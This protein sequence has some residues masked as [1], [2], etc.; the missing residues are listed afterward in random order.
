MFS[1][2][3]LV[4]A[5]DVV[6]V[7]PNPAR[8]DQKKAESINGDH[9]RLLGRR[10]LRRAHRAVPRRASSATAPTRGGPA[11]LREAA[12]LVQ[13]RMQLLGEARGMLALPVHR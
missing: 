9:I 10:G 5:F 12:P 2:D 3:E 4:D 7:N 1:Q 6:D 13:E 11:I 8:F